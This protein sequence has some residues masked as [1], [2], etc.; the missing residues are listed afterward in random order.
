MNALCKCDNGHEFSARVI[1]DE[2]DVNAITVDPAACPECGSEE[3][4][5]IVTEDEW[6]DE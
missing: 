3:I 4:E 2:P 6:C 1:A 5:V